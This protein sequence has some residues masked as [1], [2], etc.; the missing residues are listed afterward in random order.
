MNQL[1]SDILAMWTPGPI[2]ILVV[3]IIAILIFGKRLPEIARGMGK[4]LH[5]FKK[6][7]KEAKDTKEDIENDVK[8]AVGLNEQEVGNTVN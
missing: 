5:E 8:D 6:G 1:T 4:S 7:I 3:L 2:E